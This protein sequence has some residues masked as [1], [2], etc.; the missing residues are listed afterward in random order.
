[1]VTAKGL[2][3]TVAE[4]TGRGR[5]ERRCGARRPGRRTPLAARLLEAPAHLVPVHD[6]PPRLQVVRAL[7]LVLEVVGVL[8]DVDA[9]EWRLPGGDRRVL[10]GRARDLE[11]A[12]RPVVDEPGPAASELPDARCVHLL[13][14]LVEAAERLL[15]RAGE[16]PA[17]LAAAVRAHDLPEEAVVGVA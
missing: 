13:L 14:E 5:G 10:V 15:D 9:E 16:G 8:P 3:L 12:A 7:V 17:R 1:M 6:V 11:A 4:D 2:Q